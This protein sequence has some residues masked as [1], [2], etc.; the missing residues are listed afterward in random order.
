MQKKTKKKEKRVSRFVNQPFDFILCIVIFILL[1]AGVIMVL[2]ASAPSALAEGN[3]S[4]TYAG[5]QFM[6]AVI[7]I[8]AMF[9]IS[10]IDYRFYKKFYW[11]IYFISCA[12]LLLVVIPG[13]GV[14]AGGA[15]RWIAFPVIGQFQPSEITKIGIIVFYAG[16]LSDHKEE[17]TDFWKGFVKP[18]CFLIPPIGILYLVQNHLSASVIIAAVS[19]IMLLIAGARMLYFMLAGVAGGTGIGALLLYKVTKGGGGEGN[20]RIGRILSFL[21]PWQDPQGTGWQVIQSLYAIGS[22][23]LFGT[24]LGESKQKYL[25]I[26]EPQNDFIFS[27]VAEELGFVGCVIIISLFAVLIWRGILIAM[28]APDTFG[29]LLAIGIISLVAL[30]VILNI[31]VVTSSVPNT[32]DTTSIF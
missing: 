30:Q 22:G 3:E 27:I 28:K 6:F 21:D 18:L 19:C 32:R 13:L 12:I 29:G 16:Y 7:G 17:L 25:Y 8:I 14:N 20:F 10:K 9:I 24:G 23:G 1:A 26:S 11:P 4:Y 5:K 31:A 2:S 15:T